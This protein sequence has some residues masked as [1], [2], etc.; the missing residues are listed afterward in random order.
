V[1]LS[2]APPDLFVLW[3]EY[4]KGLGGQKAARDFTP[5]EKG[6]NKHNYSHRRVFW[7][8]V[9]QMIESRGLSSDVA[10]DIIQAAY[11]RNN[12][13][14]SILNQM[15]QDRMNKVDRV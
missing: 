9:D 12:S 7:A 6:A 14:T 10:I 5:T 13:V 2:S 15:K 11:G 1:R 3:D 8:K 4:D